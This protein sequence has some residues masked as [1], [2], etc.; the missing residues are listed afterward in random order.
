MFWVIKN[1]WYRLKKAAQAIN[2]WRYGAQLLI[3]VGADDQA[4]RVIERRL[5]ALYD[6]ALHLEAMA[7]DVLYN[8]GG[9]GPAQ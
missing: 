1:P 6:P 7:R 4:L 5:M 9:H 2:W 8:G 3:R